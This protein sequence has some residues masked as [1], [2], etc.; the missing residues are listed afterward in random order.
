METT[1]SLDEEAF[2]K[3]EE[4]TEKYLEVCNKLLKVQDPTFDKTPSSI[5]NCSLV[6]LSFWYT[7]K[8]EMTEEEIK[9]SMQHISN[10]IARTNKTRYSLLTEN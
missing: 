5:I 2:E 6:L 1:M 10:I 9:Q 4:I 7:G 8:T 3:G